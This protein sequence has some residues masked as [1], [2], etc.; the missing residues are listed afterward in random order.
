MPKRIAVLG[1]G[2]QGSGVGTDF[3]RAG[4]DVTFIE[5][6]P[7]HVEA[8]RTHGLRV[9][10]PGESIL[11]PVHAIH[12]CE[13]ATLREKFDLVFTLVKAYDTRWSVEL[14][15]PYLADDGLVIGLQNGMTIDTVADVVGAHRTIGSV[16]EMASNMYEPG[17]ANRQT[18]TSGSWFA[19]GGYDS[20]AQHR[21]EEVAE[22]LRHAGSVQIVD[23]IRSSKWMKLVVNA[24][25]LVP[26]AILNL[27][28]NDAVQVP[29]MHDF[30]L[31]ACREAVHTA[32]ATGNR[33]VPIFGLE[34]MD[35]ADP[36]R[37]VVELLDAVLTQFSSPDTR[38]TVL[39]DWD[40]GRHSEVDEVNG[41]VVDEQAKLGGTAPYNALTVEIAHRI[42]R[43]ELE[44][45]PENVELLVG[46]VAR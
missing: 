42:E 21:V 19:L 29:G 23:D 17:I 5:Q 33:M 39:Q 43:G 30:M 24:G 8:M 25:E 22:V 36:D 34:G 9:N 2:A 16:I 28:L 15:A 31:E 26:S 12:L 6:W 7:A 37:F 3:V 45:R 18:P 44:A 20:T 14:I 11:T 13:V 4:Y 40:K 32:V 46:H 1:S 27:P 38:T 35:L 41:L 10:L